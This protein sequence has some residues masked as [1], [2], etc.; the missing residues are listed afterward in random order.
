MN[1]RCGKGV[2]SCKNGERCS[3]Y[4]WCGK[5]D[6]HCNLEEGCQSKFGKCESITIKITKTKTLIQTPSKGTSTEKCGKKH[7]SCKEGY[8][9]SKY[10]WYGKSKDYCEKV[11]GCQSK[12][13]ECWKY[14]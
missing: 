11:K 9:C 7:G 6:K 8:C 5:T 13:G 10:G 2:G 3:K 14:E 1:G 12:F 4:G